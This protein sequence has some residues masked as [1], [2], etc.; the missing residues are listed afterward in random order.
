MCIRDRAHV[1][2]VQLLESGAIAGPGGVDQ[3][4]VRGR[5]LPLFQRSGV[6]AFTSTI[7]VG[8]DSWTSRTPD[9]LKRPP[10][11]ERDPE[12]EVLRR[13]R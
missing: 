8:L 6:H 5:E 12:Q 3:V 7:F 13:A 1:A 10:A 4:G 9:R 11:P 2:A